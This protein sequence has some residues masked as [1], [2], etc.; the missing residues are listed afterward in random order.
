[1]LAQLPDGAAVL[2]DLKSTSRRSWHLYLQTL[3]AARTQVPGTRRDLGYVVYGWPEAPRRGYPKGRSA[4]WDC[5]LLPLHGAGSGFLRSF[6]VGQEEALHDALGALVL[7]A[8]LDFR[9][10]P[11]VER[12]AS[13][14]LCPG[15]LV[16]SEWLGWHCTGCGAGFYR[17]GCNCS[18]MHWIGAA[19]DA[20]EPPHDPACKALHSS[21]AWAYTGRRGVSQREVSK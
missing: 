1:M 5:N 6:P 10:A 9:L 3:E 8:I 15:C 17:P 7:H 20:V 18:H 13:A 12:F 2:L 14:N 19:H 16:T 21:P 4:S 11:A